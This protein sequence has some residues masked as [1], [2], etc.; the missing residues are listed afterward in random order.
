MVSSSS[1]TV[2]FRRIVA[3]SAV[4]GIIIPNNGTESF[5]GGFSMSALNPLSKLRANLLSHETEL[6]GLKRY[7][8]NKIHNTV[9]CNSGKYGKKVIQIGF[10]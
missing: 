3:D 10:R 8:Y 6:T 5:Q 4:N 9:K 2:V 7:C 1:T